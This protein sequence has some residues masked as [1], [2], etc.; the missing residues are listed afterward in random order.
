MRR[1]SLIV[2]RERKSASPS[3]FSLS[4]GIGCW[5]WDY[6]PGDQCPTLGP[7]GW[8]QPEACCQSSKGDFFMARF[9]VNLS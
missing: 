6:P 7:E 3:T 9:C 1:P 5:P 4:P 8:I 2:L